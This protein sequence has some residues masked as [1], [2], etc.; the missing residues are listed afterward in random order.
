MDPLALA[1]A[2]LA[3]FTLTALYAAFSLN[4]RLNALRQNCFVTSA[5]GYR[6]RWINATEAERAQAEV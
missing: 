2:A 1:T 6:V 4:R 5:K 3:L